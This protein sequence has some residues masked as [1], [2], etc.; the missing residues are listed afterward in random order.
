MQNV[1][2]NTEAL[3]FLEHYRLFPIDGQRDHPENV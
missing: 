1:D 2:N 3:T